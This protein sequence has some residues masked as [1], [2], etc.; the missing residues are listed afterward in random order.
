[1]ES[2]SNHEN[3]PKRTTLHLDKDSY[4]KMKAVFGLADYDTMGM[5]GKV[6]MNGKERK[7]DIQFMT[8]QGPWYWLTENSLLYRAYIKVDGLNEQ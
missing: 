1:M 7:F 3:G 6:F 2:Q 5:G 8:H 4:E